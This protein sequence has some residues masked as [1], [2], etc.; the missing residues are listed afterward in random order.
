MGK[1][2]VVYRGD[3]TIAIIHPAPKSRRPKEPENEWLER[4][5]T[6]AMQQDEGLIGRPYD[7]IDA[8]ELPQDRTYRGLWR[9]EKGNGI[10]IA[11]EEKEAWEESLKTPAQ[12][13]MEDLK[14]RL[15]QLENLI[16]TN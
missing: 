1:V 14:F 6:R 12:K 11:M 3:K 15:T 5:F 8:S 2:R 9:G 16:S 13:E 10:R 4:V 7:D